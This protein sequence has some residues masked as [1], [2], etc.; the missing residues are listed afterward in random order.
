MAIT[1]ETPT[2]EAIYEAL[3][4]VPAD[5]MMRLRA[6]LNVP[7]SETAEAEQSAWRAVSAHS[8]S[9]F[10]EEENE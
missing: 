1:I 7:V 6:M 10:F 8:A 9:R 3:K 5:E 4:Q 2:A